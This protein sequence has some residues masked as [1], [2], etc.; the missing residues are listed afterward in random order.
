M[1][2]AAPT[3]TRQQARATS[4]APSHRHAQCSAAPCST[5]CMQSHT[6]PCHDTQQTSSRHACMSYP[7]LLHRGHDRQRGPHLPAH[8]TPHPPP[9]HHPRAPPQPVSYPPPLSL[10]T[11]LSLATQLC[12]CNPQLSRLQPS[13]QARGRQ[14]AAW[15]KREGCSKREER[16]AALCPQTLSSPCR[17]SAPQTPHGMIDIYIH[18]SGWEKPFGALVPFPPITTLRCGV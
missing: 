18:G 4:P 6:C 13:P 14:E 3:W 1:P 7:P 5:C 17:V 8:H 10:S 2:S 16:A 11:P 12:A 15:S 9:H